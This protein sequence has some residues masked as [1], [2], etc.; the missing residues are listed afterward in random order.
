MMR[1]SMAIAMMGWLAACGVVDRGAA[2]TAPWVGQ[3]SREE[4]VIGDVAGYRLQL[5]PSLYLGRYSA[6]Y[7]INDDGTIVGVGDIGDDFGC[8]DISVAIAWQGS[9]VHNINA[10]IAAWYDL[11]NPPPGASCTE[12]YSAA[13]DVNNDGDVVVPTSFFGDNS[14]WTWNTSNGLKGGGF[15][16]RLGGAVAINNRGELVGY[17]DDGQY[18]R[19][20]A[21]WPRTGP[22]VDID[23]R[24]QNSIAFGISDDGDIL[25]CVEGVVARRRVGTKATASHEVCGEDLPIGFGLYVRNVGGITRDGVAAFSALRN[26]VPTALVWRRNSLTDAGWSPGAASDISERGR[27][28]GWAYGAAARIPRAVTRLRNGAVQWLPTPT[29]NTESRAYGVNKCG[30]IVGYVFDA[31]GSQH[32]ALWRADSCD[33]AGSW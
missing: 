13:I 7:A 23:P 30:D 33:A 11:G 25:G 18:P 10:D 4:S 17:V 29:A 21:L 20:A 28:V 26:S 6:A 9:T 5:L 15:G 14:N 27:V 24:E 12:I 31:T 3:T 2:P 1:R 19:Y 32:A 8:H 16:G 22:L